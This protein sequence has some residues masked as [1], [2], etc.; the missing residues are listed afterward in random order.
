MYALC[1]DDEDGIL[2]AWVDGSYAKSADDT[3]NGG[4]SVFFGDGDPDNTSVPVPLPVDVFSGESDKL[5]VF[6]KYDALR[7]ELYASLLAL[8]VTTAKK[9]WSL[10]S[11]L[12]AKMQMGE[13]YVPRRKD[14]L[15]IKQDSLV[16]I[17][18]LRHCQQIDSAPSRWTIDGRNVDWR[19]KFDWGQ[20]VDTVTI[21]EY[22]DVLDAWWLATRGRCV[23]LQHVKAHRDAAGLKEWERLDFKGN[24][25]ADTL[26][27]AGR[28]MK[29]VD[30]E[31]TNYP[32]MRR[33]SKF[34]KSE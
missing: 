11:N 15:V 19:I 21:F 33:A 18:L 29:L 32:L 20:I 13:W 16:A 24:A 28:Q 31:A 9:Y 30:F 1:T 27:K 7:A 25:K 3:A 17:A 5:F 8:Y 4:A 10:C 6:H 22:Q 2:C 14:L 26:A 23:K 12:S 34:G